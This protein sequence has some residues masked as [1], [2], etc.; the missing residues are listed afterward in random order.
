MTDNKAGWVAL[1]AGVVAAG[2]IIYNGMG[3]KSKKNTKTAEPVR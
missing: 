2:V 1:A 3:K